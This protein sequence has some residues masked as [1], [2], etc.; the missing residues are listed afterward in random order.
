M[1]EWS[2]LYIFPTPFLRPSRVAQVL[3]IDCS[4]SFL[5]EANSIII[6][7]LRSSIPITLKL[8]FTQSLEARLVLVFYPM[9]P[10]ELLRDHRSLQSS[11]N[12]ESPIHLVD[13]NTFLPIFPLLRPFWFLTRARPQKKILIFLLPKLFFTT[14]NNRYYSIHCSPLSPHPF[15]D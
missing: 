7:K 6:N 5:M 11:L 14:F 9:P 10:S 15:A 12:P 8:D 2:G 3:Y 13:W 1:D 4:M